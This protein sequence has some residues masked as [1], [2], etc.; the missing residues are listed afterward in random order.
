MLQSSKKPKTRKISKNIN[1]KGK[2]TVLWSLPGIGTKFYKPELTEGFAE[3]LRDNQ[4]DEIIMTGIMPPFQFVSGV[5]SREHARTRDH[6]VN[7]KYYEGKYTAIGERDYVQNLDD[8]RILSRREFDKIKDVFRGVNIT[9][10][11]SSYDWD[12]IDVEMREVEKLMNNVKGLSTKKDKLTA[13]LSAYEFSEELIGEV[14]EK[15]GDEEADKLIKYSEEIKTFSH[16]MVDPEYV[17]VIDTYFDKLADIFSGKNGEN[18][19]DKKEKKQLE[20]EEKTPENE[21]EKIEKIDAKGELSSLRSLV[22]TI[23]RIGQDITKTHEQTRYGRYVVDSKTMDVAGKKVKKEYCDRIKNSV[24]Y[25]RNFKIVDKDSYL[26]SNSDGELK[27]VYE[28]FMRDMYVSCNFNKVIST[29]P[30]STALV[31]NMDH[32]DQLFSRGQFAR[33]LVD[34]G[35]NKNGLEVLQHNVVFEEKSDYFIVNVPRMV[36]DSLEEFTRWKEMAYRVKE[37]KA[38]Q[39]VPYTGGITIVN[40]GDSGLVSIEFL[41]SQYLKVKARNPDVEEKHTRGVVLADGHIGAGHERDPE[42]LVR[43]SNYEILETTGVTIAQLNPEYVVVAGDMING[44]YLK[45]IVN[46]FTSP[47]TT[48]S[49]DQ[50]DGNVRLNLMS[51]IQDPQRQLSELHQYFIKY[52]SEYLSEGGDVYCASGNHFNKSGDF[53]YDEALMFDLLLD[54]EQKKSKQMGRYAELLESRFESMAS[55]FTRLQATVD[56]SGSSIDQA[57]VNSFY[58]MAQT[59]YLSLVKDTIKQIKDIVGENYLGDSFEKAKDHFGKEGVEA[60]TTL[61][62]NLATI[63]EELESDELYTL[64][65]EIL[66]F[67]NGNWSSQKM[68]F[69]ERDIQRLTGEISERLEAGYF[70]GRL[71]P[72]SGTEV[73][74]GTATVAGMPA[75]LTHKVWGGKNK[76]NNLMK[77]AL[78]ASKKLELAISAHHHA[79][80]MG[81][82]EGV[83]GLICPGMQSRNAYAKT[84]PKSSAPRGFYVVDTYSLG[85]GDEERKRHVVKFVTEPIVDKL[86]FEL[87]HQG[88][89]NFGERRQ[90]LRIPGYEEYTEEFLNGDDVQYITIED[91]AAS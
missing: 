64:S 51:P 3:Y 31:R 88:K 77:H 5:K 13:R 61:E 22:S 39:R 55:D 33:F 79:P 82:A 78:K 27:S 21:K 85:E 76:I 10:L 81:Y 59:D 15:R 40:N 43:M 87:L 1:K 71:V 45:Q 17:E 44:N 65:D 63:K 66:T 16:H 83:L 28:D 6:K 47:D 8:V 14:R 46:V 86:Y 34:F 67:L 49:Q 24:P 9:Y 2:R 89:T 37:T 29:T 20:K 80:H 72:I 50:R 18:E 36:D 56:L 58:S 53:A 69:I 7:E 41:P 91:V 30:L 32:A 60:F 48:Q 74:G 73:G 26:H 57:T 4:V 62:T 68:S 42:D 11:L 12:N 38:A 54:A 35:I 90:Q 52:L 75:Y 19:V 23:K 84:L 70:G 25:K